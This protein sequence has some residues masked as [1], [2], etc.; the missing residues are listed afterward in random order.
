LI[1]AEGCGR[2]ARVLEYDP[3]YCDT[4]ITRWQNYTGKSATLDGDRRAFDEIAETR[5][6][7]D[8]SASDHIEQRASKKRSAGGRRGR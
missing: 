6:T 7:A 4:I 5:A 2:Q 8:G 1:A 3:L